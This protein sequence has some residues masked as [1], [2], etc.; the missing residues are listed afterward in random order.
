MQS[1]SSVADG[2]PTEIA[3]SLSIGDIDASMWSTEWSSERDDAHGKVSRG[4]NEIFAT[5]SV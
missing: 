2:K 3:F 5:R 1:K 4:S